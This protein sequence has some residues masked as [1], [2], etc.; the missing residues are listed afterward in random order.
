MYDLYV[1]PCKKNYAIGTSHCHTPPI[2]TSYWDPGMTL[3]DYFAAKAM[4]AMFLHEIELDEMEDLDTVTEDIGIRSY[5]MADAMLK[6][7][8]L[9]N[10]EE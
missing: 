7:R 6:A 9:P 8:E 2:S 4:Q 10:K 5:A 1:F 3:R